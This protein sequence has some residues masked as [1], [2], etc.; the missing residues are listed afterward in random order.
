MYYPWFLDNLEAFFGIL[1]AESR[2]KFP[3]RYCL[4]IM[5]WYTSA[6]L[7]IFYFMI[8]SLIKADSDYDTKTHKNIRTQMCQQIIYK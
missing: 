4:Q 5:D 6:Y 1:D 7:T 2:R 8:S 3:I